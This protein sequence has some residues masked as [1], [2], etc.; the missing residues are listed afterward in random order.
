MQ[1]L[2]FVLTC[3][4]NHF[5]S[6]PSKLENVICLV[7]GNSLVECSNLINVSILARLDEAKL[8]KCHL[9][10]DIW[11]LTLRLPINES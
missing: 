1:N 3:Y 11:I 6:V 5:L 9:V 7:P 4:L 10:R 8:L 2:C